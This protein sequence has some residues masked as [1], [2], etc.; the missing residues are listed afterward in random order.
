MIKTNNMKK[1]FY[2]SPIDNALLNNQ[3]GAI[4]YMIMYITRYQDTFVSSYLFERNINQLLEIG[5][6]LTPLLDS[7]IFSYNYVVDEWPSSHWKN[8]REIVPYNGSIFSL[9]NNYNRVFN[10]PD[11][12]VTWEE[13]E[14]KLAKRT[15]QFENS[16]KVYKV[17][18]HINLLASLSQHFTRDEH[19]GQLHVCNKHSVGLIKMLSETDEL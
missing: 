13:G 14:I 5:I 17:S 4:E 7:N 8:N 12:Q 10:D 18:Y 9:R 6:S 1:Y 16:R 2:R 11:L 15:K 19:T 3:I